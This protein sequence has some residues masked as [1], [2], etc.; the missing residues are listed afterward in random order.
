M[1]ALLCPSPRHCTSRKEDEIISLLSAKE[2][3]L[4]EIIWITMEYIR[5]RVLL[6][7]GDS[8]SLRRSP[9][10]IDKATRSVMRYISFIQSHY[11]SM[12]PIVSEAARIAKYVPHIED[13]FPLN[14]MIMEMTPF[15]QEKLAKE[16]ESFLNQG[17]RFLFLL[18]NSYFIW[19]GL[20]TLN[21]SSSS[22]KVYVAAL[23][24]K[25]KEYKES[26]LQ[27][28]WAPL[29]KLLFNTKPVPFWKN[30][31]PQTM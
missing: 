30:Y 21:H 25:V 10:D 28:S 20:S 12:S 7:I 1:C 4:D 8:D 9:S 24:D 23:S 27:V 2:A 26:Y 16:S 6:S 14:S 19:E 18:N 5:T 11:S 29:L 3:K 13:L 22:L 15:L 17:L 31:N